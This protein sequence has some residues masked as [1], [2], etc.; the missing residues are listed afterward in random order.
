[1]VVNVNDDIS[2]GGRIRFT[3]SITPG[4][5]QRKCTGED[6]PKKLLVFACRE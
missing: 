2:H 1:M 5:V 3:P 6:I 4:A